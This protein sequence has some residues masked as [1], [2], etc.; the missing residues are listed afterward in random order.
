MNRIHTRVR[1]IAASA[2]LVGAMLA[3]SGSAM[4]AS[5]NIILK[6]AAGAVQSCATGGFSFTKPT[7]PP[8]TGEFPASGASVTLTGSSASPCFGAD[9][10]RTLVPGALSVTVA[11]VTLNGQDQG[12]N[13]VSITGNLTSGNG[14]NNYTINFAS[15]RTFTV[16]QNTGLNPTVGSGVYHIYNMNSVPEPDTLWLALAGL[17]ALAFLGRRKRKHN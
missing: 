10:T 5:Y 7:T 8:L 12:P 16:T 11:N 13:V 9:S 6:S 2:A 17:G 1:H 14:S 3:A 15:N 4:A